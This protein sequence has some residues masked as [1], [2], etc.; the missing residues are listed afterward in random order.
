MSNTQEVFTPG[1]K[2]SEAQTIDLGD[3]AEQQRW[4]AW[5]EEE[6]TSKSGERER[7]KIPYDPKT[8]RKAATNDPDTWCT[9]K[10]AKHRW[11]QMQDDD[12]VGGVGIVLGDL[13][14]GSHR[15]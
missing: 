9:R 15:P 14:D 6:R 8:G 12:T 5:R 2:L 3:L 13:G 10:G 7:T 11:R 4:V 1:N